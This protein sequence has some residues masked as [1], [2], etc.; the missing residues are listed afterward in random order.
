MALS[1]SYYDFIRRL[2]PYVVEAAERDAAM[3]QSLSSAPS[4]ISSADEFESSLG[5]CFER[6]DEQAISNLAEMTG[7]PLS[8]IRDDF[9]RVR[10]MVRAQFS[11]LYMGI[12]MEYHCLLNFALSG[13]RVFSFSD[14]LGDHLAN[15]EINLKTDLIRLPFDTCLFQF[16][17][18]AVLNAL[19]NLSGDKGRLAM[20]SRTIDYGS[21]VSAFLTVL[22]ASPLPGSKLLICAFH[23]KQP[24]KCYMA[25]KREIYLGEGWSLEQALRTD[26]EK[27]TPNNLGVSL[28][29]DVDENHVGEA[30]SESFYTDGLMFFR[31]ML[32]AVLY[33]GSEQAELIPRRSE[34][35]A[36]EESAAKILSAPKRRKKLQEASRFSSLDYVEAGSSVSPIVVQRGAVTAA[37][38]SSGQSK[39]NIRFMVRGHWRQ[40]PHGPGMAERRLVWITPYY[41]GPEVADLVSKPYLVK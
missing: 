14:N 32:N 12:N 5:A 10:P 2:R 13:K 8:A 15:T 23:A 11:S 36:I 24:D 6:A 28:A 9:E 27:L 38:L 16:T 25:V 37:G 3:L 41:K 39:P 30:T 26:W 19:Y 4:V 40:Q 18:K 33:L 7:A 31:A 20:N 1:P 35:S 17:S 22:P 21:P 29:V 34:R